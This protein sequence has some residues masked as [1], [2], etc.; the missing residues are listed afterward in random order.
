[1]PLA[2]IRKFNS[3]RLLPRLFTATTRQ[4][5]SMA[6][7]DWNHS[8]SWFFS[9]PKSIRGL[10]CWYIYWLFSG[11]LFYLHSRPSS[12]VIDTILIHFF[13]INT[14]RRLHWPHPRSR[15]VVAPRDPW[16]WGDSTFV[17]LVRGILPRPPYSVSSISGRR[18]F[19][20]CLRACLGRPRRLYDEGPR[21]WG[22]RKKRKL[23]EDYPK[24]IDLTSRL[25][26]RG[27]WCIAGVVCYY[28]FGCTVYN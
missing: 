17:A 3:R 28:P 1:M 22:N 27:P 16:H 19:R 4:N 13:T 24:T 20:Q 23:L 21:R 12:P 9:A 26:Y 6:A 14:P 25:S 11:R 7:V 2:I 5:S 15:T 18:R 8:N 10:C